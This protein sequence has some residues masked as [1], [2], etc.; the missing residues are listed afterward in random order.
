[1]NEG[2]IRLH[3][4]PDANPLWLLEPF[5]KAQAWVDIVLNANYTQGVMS[6]RGNIITIERGQLGWSE[7]TMAKRWRWSRDK[8][9]R[10][11]SYLEDGQNIRQQKTQITTIITICNYDKYQAVTTTDDTTDNT[12]DNTAEKQ[13]KNNRRYTIKEREEREERKEEE[14]E[15]LQAEPVLKVSRKKAKPKPDFSV[16]STFTNPG[17]SSAFCATLWAD[18][19]VSKKAPYRNQTTAEDALKML[20]ELSGGN[21]ALATE[22]LRIAKVSGWQSFHWHFKNQ[23]T[24]NHASTKSNG[25]LAHQQPFSPSDVAT[26]ISRIENDPRLTA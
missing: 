15:C 19:C 20:H 18:W 22:A 17:F 2:W 13:Q 23:N 3:R 10:F 21:E 8:V 1:M 16:T 25:R 12:T 9:R 5:T 7:V 11:L 6:V 26:L 14:E 4:A 24:T